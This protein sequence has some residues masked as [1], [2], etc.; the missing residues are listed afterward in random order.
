MLRYLAEENHT[1]ARDKL[2][3]TENNFVVFAVS[4]SGHVTSFFDSELNIFDCW[5]NQTRHLPFTDKRTYRLKI[6]PL[7][8]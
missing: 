6:T 8:P 1:E 7:L 2:L 5:S 4:S 3:T